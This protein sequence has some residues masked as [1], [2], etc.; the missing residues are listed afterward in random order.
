MGN[1]R[2]GMEDI[3]GQAAFSDQGE[4]IRNVARAALAKAGA[5]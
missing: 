4:Y 2:I 3:A 5:A 1:N